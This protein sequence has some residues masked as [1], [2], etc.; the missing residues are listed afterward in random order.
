GPDGVGI[1]RASLPGPRLRG[2]APAEVVLGI[3]PEHIRFADAS[4]LRGEVV[5]VEYMGARQVVTVDTAAGR[6]RVR[7]GNDIRVSF[8][9]TVG[10]EPDPAR[11]VLFDKASGQALPSALFAGVGRG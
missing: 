7:C 11:A 5:G 2:S 8:G 1:A 10:L 3:R 9:E 4:P 6:A